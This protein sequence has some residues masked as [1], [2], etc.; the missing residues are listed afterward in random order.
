MSKAVDGGFQGVKSGIYVEF[1]MFKKIKIY[2]KKCEQELKKY[3]YIFRA[4]IIV[5]NGLFLKLLFAVYIPEIKS[6]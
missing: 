4:Q 1:K 3:L 6:L 2:W 5:W